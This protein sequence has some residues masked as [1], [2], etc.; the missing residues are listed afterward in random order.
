MIHRSLAIERQDSVAAL[1]CY[2][3]AKKLPDP[4]TTM[5]WNQAGVCD[6]IFPDILSSLRAHMVE[7]LGSLKD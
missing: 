6:E 1:D 2:E 5:A 7:N 4:P 3:T